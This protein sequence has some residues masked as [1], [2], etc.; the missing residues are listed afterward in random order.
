V[1][2]AVYI[3]KRELK[4]ACVGGSSNVP[5][6]FISLT[7]NL[8]MIGMAV[9]MALAAL[10]IATTGSPAG[11]RARQPVELSLATVKGSS[12]AAY[13]AA[14]HAMMKGMDQPYTGDADVDFMRGMIPHHE[15]AIAMARV[16]LRYGRDP[17]VRQL[18]TGV[19]NAQEREIDQ[20]RTWLRE[21][22]DAPK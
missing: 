20:M 15:G 13:K 14:D 16:A 2:K 3:D 9:W 1:F 6:G 4:C 22:G 11:I 7:E 17:Q 5:L 8:M 18:A 19:I 21:H 10:G 12:T